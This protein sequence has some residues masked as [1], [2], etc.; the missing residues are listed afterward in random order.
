MKPIIDWTS[1]L[2]NPQLLTITIDAERWKEV[3]AKLFVRHLPLLAKSRTR[4]EFEEA[5]ISLEQKIAL[6][7]ALRHLARRSCFST[8]IEEKLSARKLSMAAI[9]AALSECRRLGY[10]DDAAKTDHLI[11]KSLMKGKGPQLIARQLMM[12]GQ[13]PDAALLEEMKKNQTAAIAAMLQKKSA[14][15]KQKKHQLIAYLLRRGFDRESILMAINGG[16]DL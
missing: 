2:E 15:R 13:R 5:F 9:Q 14:L 6:Q 8:E 16:I 3:D 12:K 10:L 11:K 7:E 4:E 1:D